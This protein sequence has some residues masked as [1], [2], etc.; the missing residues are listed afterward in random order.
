MEQNEQQETQSPPKKQII[1]LSA[2]TL[3]EGED[4]LNQ[5]SSNLQVSQTTSQTQDN[6]NNNTTNNNEEI[7]QPKIQSDNEL[8]EQIMLAL[9][10]NQP[11]R[12]ILAIQK[13]L[14]VSD[15]K[16][17][18]FVRFVFAASKTFNLRTCIKTVNTINDP[19]VL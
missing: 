9:P 6:N 2:T 11:Q 7:A 10:T 17:L 13:F 15:L 4:P 12:K 3:S 18:R 16:K 5:S 8:V 19:Y 1:K 14:E